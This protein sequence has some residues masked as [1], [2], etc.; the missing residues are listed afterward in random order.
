MAEASEM[1]GRGLTPVVGMER[2]HMPWL[3][4]ETGLH[5]SNHIDLCV[6]ADGPC[7]GPSG[8]I[9]HDRED[10]AEVS[11]GLSSAST[12]KVHRQDAR[13]GERRTYTC[14]H[15]DGKMLRV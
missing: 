15:G 6:R 13:D 7:L 3:P 9:V 12:H 4:A 1:S 11:H 5:C 14:L 10:P 8:G 2:D